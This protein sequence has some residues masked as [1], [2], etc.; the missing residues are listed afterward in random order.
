MNDLDF[1]ITRERVEDAESIDRLNARIFGPGRFARTAARLREGAG[2]AHHLCFTARVGTYMV[3]SIR[4]WH[5]RVGIDL[6]AVLLG[7]LTIEPLFQN[8]GI[9]GALMK[10]SLEVC[11][12]QKTLVFLIGD[13]VYYKKWGFLQ[14]DLDKI[15]LPTPENPERFQVLDLTGRGLDISGALRPFPHG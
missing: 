4:Y 12:A 9:G 5:A 7:P 14:A 3:G 13:E 11:R 10:V 8:K 1:T 2:Q 6:P 15:T